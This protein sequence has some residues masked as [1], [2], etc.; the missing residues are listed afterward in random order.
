MTKRKWHYILPP[1]VYDC[2]CKKCK[3]SNLE[4]S[5]YEHHVWCYDCE[6]DI[7]IKDSYNAG[8]FY[9]PIAMKTARIIGVSFDRYI[10]KTNTIERFNIDT[11]KWD[12]DWFYYTHDRLAKALLEDNLDSLDD[13]YGDV[14]RIRG[15]E[16]VKVD[17][18]KMF[19]EVLY[20]LY[21]RFNT[22]N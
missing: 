4:W 13:R 12:K 16:F 5:E 9:G 6:E 22:E 11:L 2:T 10:L 17:N 15:K 14:T 20:G 7:D 3:G 21:E 18:F 1:S 8:L 19:D